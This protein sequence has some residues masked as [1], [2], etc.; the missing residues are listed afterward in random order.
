MATKRLPYRLYRLAAPYVTLPEESAVRRMQDRFGVA[1]ADIDTIIVSHFH[2]DHLGGAA[3]F[4]HARFVATAAAYADIAE[5]RGFAALRRAYL[6][7]LL[8]AAFAARADL[9]PTPFTGDPLPHLGPTHDLL[10]DGSLRLVALPGHAVGQIGLL[11]ATE[12]GPAL[13]IAD[14]AYMRRSVREDR[15][16]HRITERFT[17]NPAE[18]AETLTRL[19]LFA[20]ERPDVRIV[21][22]HCPEVLAEVE[23]GC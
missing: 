8:P 2:P 15:L 20:Q 23:D 3:D 7:A 21:P 4:P 13:F 19:H 14:A 16:P 6:P 5:Q 22:T 12:E 10:G 17:D 1:A 9:L 11:A 18:I